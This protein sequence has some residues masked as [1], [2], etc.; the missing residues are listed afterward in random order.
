MRLLKLVGLS[1]VLGALAAAS[2]ASGASGPPP[3]QPPAG[4]GGHHQADA[5]HHA[6]MQLF[7][8][9]LAN[10]HKV[11]REVKYLADGIETLT[12]SSDPEV[13]ARL[14]AH[15]ASM[16]ARMERGRPIHARDPLFA[17]IFR[18]AKHVTI[19]VDPLETGVRVVETSDDAY[20]VKLLH[21]HARVVNLFIERGMSEMHRDHPVPKR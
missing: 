6:D 3:A 5:D 10:R 1:V 17:E 21:E 9:L 2:L 19:H 11:T 12:Q 18:N 16:A 13:A 4:R 7:H 20:T 15:V 8:Y 14:K